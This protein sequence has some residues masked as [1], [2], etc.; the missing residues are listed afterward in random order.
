M[1]KLTQKL[2]LTWSNWLSERSYWP[3]IPSITAEVHN[4]GYGPMKIVIMI[5]NTV[6]I[7]AKFEHNAPNF[8]NDPSYV[9]LINW[10]LCQ[11]YYERQSLF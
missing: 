7:V 9:D 8:C 10:L 11:T 3:K 4:M 6:H 1:K 5:D 2:K